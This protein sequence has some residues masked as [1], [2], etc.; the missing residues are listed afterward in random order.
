MGGIVD[1]L[2]G[3]NDAPDPS[4]V[5][6]AQGQANVEAARVTALLNRANQV[7]PW[8]TQM[9]TQAPDQQGTD[10]WTSTVALD[11]RLQGI[12]DQQ[13]STAQDTIGN[14][15][16][17]SNE[18]YRK[19]VED[20]LYNRY[21]SRL[22]P[23]WQQG[24]SDLASRLAAQGITQGSQ[25]YDRATGNFDRAKT[26]AYQAALDQAIGGGEGAIQG[27]FNRDTAGRS[28]VL[29]ELNALRSGAQFGQ[30]PS[31]ASV[32][33]APVAQAAYNSYNAQQAQQQAQ[34]QGLT[35]LGNAAAMFAFGF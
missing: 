31:G 1:G 21:T 17:T 28:Q 22:D 27:Q 19:Q 11:P 18:A 33:A 32:G 9:W 23:Q 8:G 3:G 29:N 16:V 24:E 14:T 20:A 6:N 30:T 5:A 26:D 25:A 12:L 13:L 7:T 15:G 10:Q 2:F 34:M 4:A 35:S